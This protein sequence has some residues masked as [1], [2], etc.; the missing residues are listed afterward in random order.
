M[1]RICLICANEIV[2]N[3]LLQHLTGDYHEACFGS[4]AAAGVKVERSTR[5]GQR[6]LLCDEYIAPFSVVVTPAQLVV[7]LHCF[8]DPPAAGRRSLG[9]AAAAGTLLERIV[10]LRRCSEVLLRMAECVQA[11]A[12]A[13]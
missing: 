10:A 5:D 2:T 9:A 1:R 13:I 4:I 12:C 6:C 3:E 8:F 11:R 7:H